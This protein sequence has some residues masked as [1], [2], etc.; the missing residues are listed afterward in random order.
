MDIVKVSYKQFDKEIKRPIVKVVLQ[1]GTK[2]L[3]SESLLDT[4]AD[5]T[6]FHS[7]FAKGLGL[8]LKSGVKDS[9]SG[10]GE[11]EKGYYLHEID[12]IIGGMKKTIKAGFMENF[13]KNA[14]ASGVLGQKGFFENFKVTFDYKNGSVEILESK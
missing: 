7:S 2:H 3:Y 6:F 9:L 14:G 11:G 13:P 10:I 12:L 1:V 8:D 5:I 4:G